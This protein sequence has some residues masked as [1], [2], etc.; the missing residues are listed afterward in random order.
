[1]NIA[2]KLRT[3]IY[4]AFFLLLTFL[5]L[6]NSSTSL[7]YALNGLNLWFTKMIPALFPF[8]ILSGI[9]VRLQ[10]TQQFA[11]LLHPLLHPILKGGKNVTYA[12]IMGFL[13]GFPMGA[14]VTCD[15]LERN[16][17]THREA[18]FL[19]AFCNNIGPVYFCSFVI[20]LLHRQL[21]WPYLL[22]MYAL[23]FLYGAVLRRTAF[24][25]LDEAGSDYCPGGHKAGAVG[26]FNRTKRG[27]KELVLCEDKSQ[28]SLSLLEQ[29]DDAITSSI[30][31]ILMLGGYMIL[32]NLL[33]LIPHV[34]CQGSRLFSW[35]PE[36][37]APV[38]EITGG[39]GML[40][41][42][43]PLLALLVLP[44]GGLS[45]IAQTYSMIKNTSLTLRPYI[46]HK[47]V[48]TGITA[49]FYAGWHFLFPASF[50]L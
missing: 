1:M 46:I 13:C 18:E 44:F 15:L 36:V 33:N 34:L 24:R 11:T 16:M 23:P 28:R 12:V 31:S 19:L 29:V 43:R 14:K 25:D 48:L 39:L 50:L 32:F 26:F 17:I 47:V 27:N 30:Q 35:L 49:V 2:R 37:L 4:S 38:L 5:I 10:L 22:G 9:M 40:G 41:D 7:Y 45:C 6:A 21:V 20:P 3:L 8:M 42:S